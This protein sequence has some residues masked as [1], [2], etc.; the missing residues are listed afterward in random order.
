MGKERGE[1]DEGRFGPESKRHA[2]GVG[3]LRDESLLEE[4]ERGGAKRIAK[5]NGIQRGKAS[6]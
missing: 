3:E 2:C 6:C 1:D 4:E 5:D